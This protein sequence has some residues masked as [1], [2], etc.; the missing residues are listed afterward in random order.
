MAV[1]AFHRILLHLEA[2]TGWKV[3]RHHSKKGIIILSNFTP[4]EF[5]LSTCEKDM[6]GTVYEEVSSM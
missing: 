6:H 1:R 2:D 3:F 4:T 5:K